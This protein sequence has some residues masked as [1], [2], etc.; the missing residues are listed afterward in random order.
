MNEDLGIEVRVCIDGKQRCTSIQR[1]IE[2]RIPFISPNTREK[3]WYTDCPGQ[4]GG[5]PLPI[6]L[7]QRFDQLSIQ[8]VEYRHLDIHQQR[9]IFQ[10]VQLG[11]PLSAAEK[12][13]ALG[14]HWST[15]I[16]QLEKKY[17]NANGGLK[18]TLPKFDVT[19]GRPFQILASLVM[20]VY[21][22]ESKTVPHSTTMTKFL[23]RGDKPERSFQLKVEMT[24]SIFVAISTDYYDVAFG[25]IESRVA[26]VEFM[27]IG[28]L[29]FKRMN[30]Y[31]MLRLAKEIT[32]MREHLRDDF[33]DIRANTNL[34]K[35][36]YAYIETVPAGKLPGETSAREEF[37]GAGSDDEAQQERI[38]KRQREEDR[39]G[40]YYDAAAAR[41]EESVVAAGLRSK[42]Q[43]KKKNKDKDKEMSPIK[44]S[45][46][47]TQTAP[48]LVADQLVQPPPAYVP[49][50]QAPA[51]PVQA[52]RPAPIA[53]DHGAAYA[54]ALPVD[55]SHMQNRSPPQYNVSTYRNQAFNHPSYG[56]QQPPYGRR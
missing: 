34:F 42:K 12:L 14:G 54:P 1:F 31:G 9:D 44:R 37:S 25:T 29:I 51:P 50:P 47:S 35:A 52:P 56:Y 30:S 41:G 8:V 46:G 39:D 55:H 28:L 38:R 5:K 6:V 23:E 15:W 3:F 43:K 17:I 2:G 13:Q 40:N 36:I 19:R 10:R 32:K 24:L 53:M 16:T 7:K 11:M 49:R 20:M 22:P 45:P 18:D 26:P 48:Q 33:R 27:G 21:D 4:K